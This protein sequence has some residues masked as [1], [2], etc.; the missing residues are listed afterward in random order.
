V[1]TEIVARR[2]ICVLPL[3][4]VV[5]RKGEVMVQASS[6]RANLGFISAIVLIATIG[7]FLFGYDSGA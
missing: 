4:D 6:Q 2:Q 5:R 1:G 7:G 3:A